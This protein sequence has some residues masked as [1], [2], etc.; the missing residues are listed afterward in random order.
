MAEMSLNPD[1]GIAELNA[2]KLP[3][4]ELAEIRANVCRHLKTLAQ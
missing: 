4:A 2:S 3:Q 1:K